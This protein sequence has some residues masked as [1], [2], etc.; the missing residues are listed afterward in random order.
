MPHSKT[1]W[2]F[3]RFVVAKRLG[4]PQSSGA[5]EHARR[6]SAG[7]GFTVDCADGADEDTSVIFLAPH[8]I[9]GGELAAAVNAKGSFETIG[10]VSDN[11]SEGYQKEPPLLHPKSVFI[12]W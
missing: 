10:H 5:F 6:S 9:L 12:T 11:Y 8:S 4:M 2:R 7:A 3:I 1:C